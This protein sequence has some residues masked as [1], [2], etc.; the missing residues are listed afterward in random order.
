MSVDRC[1]CRNVTFKHLIELSKHLGC[2]VEKLQDATSAGHGCGMCVPY[3]YVAVQTGKSRIGLM[4]N[5]QCE[6][7][8]NEARA[9]KPQQA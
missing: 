2:N 6:R 1:I 8:L 5:A 4:S 3:I 7:V 9:N